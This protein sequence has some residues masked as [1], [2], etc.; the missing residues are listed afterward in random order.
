MVDHPF[1]DA[2]ELTND[3][4]QE[5][6]QK[7]QKILYAEIQCG[8]TGMVDSIRSQLLVYEQEFSERLYVQRYDE[9]T[10]K[11][12]DGVI[13]IGTI[14]EIESP[15]HDANVEVPVKRQKDL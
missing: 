2:R 13:E 5:R 15:D 14:E 3:E 7:C 11:N 6:I 8:H 9:F 1:V 4:L 10:A 12:P